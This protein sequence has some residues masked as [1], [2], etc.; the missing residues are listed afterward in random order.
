MI[1]FENL[2]E[3]CKGS[4]IK[5]CEVFSSGE[6]NVCSSD[7]QMHNLS[8]NGLKRAAFLEHKCTKMIGDLLK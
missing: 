4:T 7:M 1:P 6:E 5:S 8:G 2:Q 3:I